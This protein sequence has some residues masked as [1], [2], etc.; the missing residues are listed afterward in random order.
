MQNPTS[1]GFHLLPYSNDMEDV[2]YLKNFRWADLSFTGSKIFWAELSFVDKIWAELDLI[3]KIL[4]WAR[5]F[6][7][8]ERH[9]SNLYF[10]ELSKFGSVPAQLAQTASWADLAELGTLS[11]TLSWAGTDLK[12]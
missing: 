9:K 11:K 7:N 1:C 5:Q 12:N 8:S 4:S 2:K 6:Y 3:R 10:Y